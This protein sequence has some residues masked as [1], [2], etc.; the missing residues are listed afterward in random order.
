MNEHTPITA[1]YKKL[2]KDATPVYA[3]R[4]DPRF[5][6][7]LYLPPDIGADTPVLTV[8]HGNMR[9]LIAIRDVFSDF[10]R[11]NNCIILSPLFPY[12]VLGD[13]N[14]DGFKFIK[15]GDIRY[16]DLLLKMFEEVRDRYHLEA[17][18]FGLF[19]FAGGAQFT[20][21]FTL[22]HPTSLWAA[23]IAAPGSVTRLDASKPWWL[24]V[25]DVEEKFGIRLDI[26]ALRA[27][28]IHMVVGTA[29]V[30]PGTDA[31]SMA[32]MPGGRDA[33]ETA[34]E[35]LRSLEASF[36]DHG[37]VPEFDLVERKGHL[38]V[39]LAPA[40]KAFFARKLPWRREP[41]KR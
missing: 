11:W 33:G 1:F 21:R 28:P 34:L 5:S 25:G 41:L 35:R 30:D 2:R 22:L 19:G 6:Y 24:G 29:D 31:N 9:N 17:E 26:E 3:C 23:S 20:H 36:L 4:H 14:K 16:D 7:S 27:L 13:D 18:T 38:L 37:I 40:A 10:G 15:E 12:G 39:D 8:I 32:W